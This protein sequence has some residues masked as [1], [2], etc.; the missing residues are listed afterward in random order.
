MERYKEI[1]L[2]FEFQLLEN[3][4]TVNPGFVILNDF[5]NRVARHIDALARNPFPQK[6][7]AAAFRIWKQNIGGV[8]DDAAI[9]FLGYP[10]VVTAVAG[11]HVIH[12]NSQ[13]FGHNRAEAAVRVSQYQEFVR[14]LIPQNLLQTAQDY[15]DLFAETASGAEKMIRLAH[16][17]LVEEDLIQFIVVVLSGVDQDVIADL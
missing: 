7:R 9:D 14:L 13:A 12:R 16:A 17:Q 8:I 2:R 3:R 15:A 4:G 6:I 10:I 5:V 1:A 11:L